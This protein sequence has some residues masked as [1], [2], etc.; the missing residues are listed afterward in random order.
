M[1]KLT[2]TV[3][4]ENYRSA[5]RW[6]NR[7][8]TSVSA[9]VRNFFEI[10]QNLPSPGVDEPETLRSTEKLSASQILMELN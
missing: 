3:T 2:L 8:N 9:L 1:K 7:C 4:E 5:H 6:A 10:L